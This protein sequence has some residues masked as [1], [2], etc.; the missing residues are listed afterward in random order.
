MWKTWQCAN[1]GHVYSEERGAPEDGIAPGTRWA[2]VPADW[3]CP[4]CGSE[5]AQ[6]EMIEI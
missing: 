5:K 6:F 4:H 1:C 3:Y 2:D